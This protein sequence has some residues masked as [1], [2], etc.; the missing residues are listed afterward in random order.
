MK[1]TRE[2]LNAAMKEAVKVGLFPK[3]SDMDTYLKCW[4]QME[5][6]LKATLQESEE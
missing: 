2:M 5:S 6:V 4:E 3:E 1:L